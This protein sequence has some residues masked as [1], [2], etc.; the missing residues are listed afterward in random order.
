MKHEILA[1]FKKEISK[2]EVKRLEPEILA[3]FKELECIPGIHSVKLQS[4][5]VNRENRYDI[6]IVIDMDISALEVYD[7][8]EPHLRWKSKYGDLLE[9]KA[10][11]DHEE[12]E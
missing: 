9:K 6:K 11:F 3:L 5:C 12:N 10:I 1:K 8:S 2:S 4:S 7:S